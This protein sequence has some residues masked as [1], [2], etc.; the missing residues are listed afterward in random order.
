MQKYG[1]VQDGKLTLNEIC[2]EGYKP[3][4]FAEIPDAFDQ[5]TQCVFQGEIIENED[6]IEVGIEIRE[7]ENE[8]TGENYE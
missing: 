7:V 1:I 3:V 6:S 5:M 4:I 8:D 2:R